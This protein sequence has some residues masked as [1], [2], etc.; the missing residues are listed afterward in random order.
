MEP[1]VYPMVLYKGVLMPGWEEPYKGL[2][3]KVVLIQIRLR[4][5]AQSHEWT[6]NNS[7]GRKPSFYTKYNT[8]FIYKHFKRK[9]L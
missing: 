5:H 1:D 6:K 4:P 9:V 8:S 3:L 2:C 7:C